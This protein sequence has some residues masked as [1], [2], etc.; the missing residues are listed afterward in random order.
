[1]TTFHEIFE[2]QKR[3]NINIRSTDDRQ[4]NEW[5]ETYLLGLVSEIDDILDSLN[6]KR[7]RQNESRT[8]DIDNLGNDLADLTKYILSLW[9][10]YDYT[11]IDVLHFV[12]TKNEILEELYRQEF[13]DIPTDR[14]IVITDLDGTLGDWRQTFIQW[15]FS[16]HRITPIEDGSTTLQIDSDLAMR[17][18]EYFRLKEEFER[19]GQYQNILIYPD[20]LT[21]LH[22]LKD[23]F[24]AYIIAHTA[25]PWQRYYR[26]WGDTWTWICIT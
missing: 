14:L 13:E 5:T 2:Q 25:R 8:V 26:I 4:V 11:A 7:H 17:Y 6:W 9:E 23:E 12:K 20:S 10:L 22:W 21:F 16:M 24:D 18:T 3:Y 1:M 15:A 19:S